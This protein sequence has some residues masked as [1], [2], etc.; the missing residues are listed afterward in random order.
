MTIWLQFRCTIFTVAKDG[1]EGFDVQV[2]RC[3]KGSTIDAACF[4]TLRG[5][6]AGVKQHALK[7]ALVQHEAVLEKLLGRGCVG[8]VIRFDLGIQ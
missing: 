5:S 1:P 4:Y 7:E 2:Q 3:K 8:K 6:F